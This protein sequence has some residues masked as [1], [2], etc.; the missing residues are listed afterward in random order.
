MIVRV[1]G[2]LGLFAC[3]ILAGSPESAPR[4]WSVTEVQASAESHAAAPV[5]EIDDTRVDP[6]E[7]EISSDDAVGSC[8]GCSTGD[9]A[10]DDDFCSCSS[11]SCT[12]AKHSLKMKSP[13]GIWSRIREFFSLSKFSHGLFGR[14]SLATASTCEVC[15]AD[16]E[17]VC[18]DD[19]GCMAGSD[20]E[21]VDEPITSQAHPCPACMHVI[22]PS[23]AATPVPAE[24][25]QIKPVTEADPPLPQ[26]LPPTQAPVTEDETSPAPTQPASE[27]LPLKEIPVGE[28]EPGS[29][30]LSSPADHVLPTSFHLDGP[31][32]A[33]FGWIVGELHYQHTR[34]GV[35]TLRYLPL[36][37][38]D[39]FGGQVILNR[40][41]RLAG[42]KE[43][44]TVRVEGRVTK[45]SPS[46]SPTYRLSTITKAE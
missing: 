28:S 22:A 40:D 13:A 7:A 11:P 45:A 18:C 17:E 23:G 21:T 32:A 38:T 19:G 30:G 36:D 10:C 9:I 16:G 3:S 41:P 26:A 44:D 33:D 42:F 31:H 29:V 4:R 43:G 1:W 12:D 39:A 35:W 27:D 37:Q 24:G 34:G 6:G 2:T 46:G 5:S 15:L 20:E 8:V 25:V 14:R